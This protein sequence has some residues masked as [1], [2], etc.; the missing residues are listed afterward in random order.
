MQFMACNADCACQQG[1][2]GFLGCVGAGQQALACGMNLEATGGPNA[3]T[4]LQCAAAPIVGG[5][6]PGCLSQCG[7]AGVGIADAGVT[8]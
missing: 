8:D 6:G 4:L 3:V 7:V 1:V 5:P 2:V